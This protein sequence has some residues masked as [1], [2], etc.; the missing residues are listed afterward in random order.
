MFAFENQP[1]IAPVNPDGQGNGIAF[2]RYFS[3]RGWA[4]PVGVV[5]RTYR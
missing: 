1:A 4:L 5:D 3:R 2:D